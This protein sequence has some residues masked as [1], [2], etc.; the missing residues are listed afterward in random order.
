MNYV[1]NAW[2]NEG[3]T[4][5]AAE[6]AARREA[7]GMTGPAGG[8][9]HPDTSQAE[10]AYKGAP[11]PIADVETR[12]MVTTDGPAMSEDEFGVAT[13]VYFER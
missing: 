6:V 12:A 11:S 13:R 5:A 3:G 7:Y 1:L 2:G 8:E 4:V 10:M 9:S